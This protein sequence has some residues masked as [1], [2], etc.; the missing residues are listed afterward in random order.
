MAYRLQETAIHEAFHAVEADCRYRELSNATSVD[1]V[2]RVTRQYLSS[3]PPEDLERLPDKCRPGGVERSE[4]I[5]HWA[6]ELSREARRAMLVAED[7]RRLDRLT[8][9]FLIASV[10]I[11]QI[12]GTLSSLPVAPAL[13]PFPA[14]RR[15]AGR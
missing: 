1:E 5:E 14:A 9:H 15:G 12:A 7:E 10:R 11:R 2:V 3:W 13:R 6:D 8:N 4:D